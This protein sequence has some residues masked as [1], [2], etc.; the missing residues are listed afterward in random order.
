MMSPGKD[1]GYV[2]RNRLVLPRDSEK[3]TRRLFRARYHGAP[4]QVFAGTEPMADDPTRADA[5]TPAESDAAADTSLQLLSRAQAGDPPGPRRSARPLSPR[6]T[7]VGE[8]AHPAL[9]PRRRPTPTTL[10]RMPSLE[11]LDGSGSSK[12]GGKGPCGHTCVR[13]CSTGFATSSAAPGAVRPPQELDADAPGDDTSPLDR[14]IGTETAERYEQALQRLRPAD[15]EAIIV[16][17]ELGSTYEQ[18]AL[19]LGKPTP[20]PRVWRLDGRW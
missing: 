17:V 1:V 14:A 9:G 16:R 10:F 2:F 6:F 11:R 19:A 5:P 3:H 12:P 7:P 8:R 20:T 13:R 4:A 18:A 15:R